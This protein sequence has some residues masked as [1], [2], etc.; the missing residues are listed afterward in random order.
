MVTKGLQKEKEAMVNTWRGSAAGLGTYLRFQHG[1]AAG[2][3]SRQRARRGGDPRNNEFYDETIE[4]KKRAVE[5]INERIRALTADVA[6]RTTTAAKL[7]KEIENNK[8]SRSCA[9]RS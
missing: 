9:D 1:S 4:E 6:E 8:K 2:Y 3:D 5:E 7:T